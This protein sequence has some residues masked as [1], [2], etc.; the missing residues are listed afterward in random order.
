M[1]QVQASPRKCLNLTEAEVQ[2]RREKGLCFHCNE[3]FSPS[4]HCKCELQIMMVRVADY[5][6][7][8]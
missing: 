4:N 5:D 6:C 2:A 7:A 8:R 1:Q 3:K